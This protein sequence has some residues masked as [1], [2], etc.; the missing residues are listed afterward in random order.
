MD[1]LALETE[2]RPAASAAGRARAGW[3][4]MTVESRAC[5]ARPALRDLPRRPRVPGRGRRRRGAAARGRL[6]RRVSRP[7]RS[8][9][10]SRRSTPGTARR[11]GGS[12]GRSPARSRATRRS[13]SPRARARRW[14]RTTSR[15]SSAASRSTSGSSPR[16]STH[17]GVRP[18]PRNEGRRRRVPR[19]VPH[20]ARA[21]DRRRAAAAARALGRGARAA[22]A[23]GSL[24]RLRRHVLGAAARG[25]AGD[26]RRQARGRRAAPRRSSPPIPGCLMHLRGR[27]EQRRRRGAGRPPRHRARAGRRDDA[28]SR[29]RPAALPRDRA[30]QARRRAHAGG[31]RL[32]DGPAAGRTASRR[33]AALRDVE[34]LRER[35]HE[36]RMRVIDDL[37]AHVAR[38]RD[39]V[40]ARGGARLLRA[41]RRTRRTPTSPTSAGG[42]ARSS[43]R[44]RSRW[45]PRRSA[46]T[47]R[48]RRSGV[49]PV[50][51]DLGEYIL[52]LAGEHPVHIIAPAIEKTA[53]EVAELLS[54]VEGEPVPAGARGADA[55]GAPPA[56]RDVPRTPTSASPARTSASATRARSASSRTRATAGSSRACRASTSR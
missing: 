23:A 31:A 33:W 9:A 34:A 7:A 27:A 22:A 10:A 50:E 54:R 53:E 25:L 42:A 44:S 16:S 47:R 19:L 39:A 15:S 40:E 30:A 56:A 1:V 8:A 37:D 4:A 21:A 29:S 17:A 14:P 55:G 43:R 5:R 12:R 48:S 2:A 46:S 11:R 13:S 3:H 49:A 28:S 18:L 6:R 41:R 32:L 52:Q 36:A 24:L 45:R 51:T 26:G 20:A 38:F 35:A